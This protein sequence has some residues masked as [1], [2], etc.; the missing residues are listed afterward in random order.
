[1]ERGKVLDSRTLN[2]WNSLSSYVQLGEPLHNSCFGLLAVCPSRS[3]L[4][5]F[6]KG[7]L[8]PLQFAWAVLY[9][10]FLVKRHGWIKGVN[11]GGCSSISSGVQ[12][13]GEG[14]ETTTVGGFD[15]P[16]VGEY[17]R[18]VLATIGKKRLTGVGWWMWLFDMIHEFQLAISGG[19]YW[20]SADSWL[21]ICIATLAK[22]NETQKGR[23]KPA[24]F[25]GGFGSQKRPHISEFSGGFH[26][27]I[28]WGRW[29][30]FDDVANGVLQ[31][32]PSVVSWL[33]MISFPFMTL[34]DRLVGRSGFPM[35]KLLIKKS[36]HGL[37]L[38][39][40]T[41]HVGMETKIGHWK[42]MLLLMVHKSC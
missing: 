33:T 4:S 10:F 14:R 16:D 29:S 41:W 19:R 12:C 13:Q 27:A 26:P 21:L 2:S 38:K 24:G 1:M 6:Q 9:S 11:F 25:H 30:H 5:G 28:F 39:S 23:E 31:P 8:K 36:T 32:P 20:Q 18:L 17:R 34:K 15:M 3:H 35:W 7:H 42:K 22:H 40:T 37:P